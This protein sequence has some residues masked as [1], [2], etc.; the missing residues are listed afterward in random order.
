[1]TAQTPWPPPRIRALRAELAEST[2]IFA[3][4]FHR[5][6]RTIEDWEQ[7]RRRP[8]ALVMMS[9]TRLAARRRPV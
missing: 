8:D 3:S 5:S 6:S 9:L 1:M 2:A 7:G 4:R